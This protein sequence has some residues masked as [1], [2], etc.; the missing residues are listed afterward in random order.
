[1]LNE[2]EKCKEDFYYFLDNYIKPDNETRVY[3]DLIKNNTRIQINKENDKAKD[4]MYIFVLYVFLFGDCGNIGVLAKTILAASK[5]NLDIY[6][7]C[8]TLPDFLFDKKYHER[9]SKYLYTTKKEGYFNFASI[10]NCSDCV[11]FI[12]FTNLINIV[13]IKE[14]S[15]TEIE[16]TLEYCFLDAYSALN[17]KYYKNENVKIFILDNITEEISV[18]F[19]GEIYSINNFYKVGYNG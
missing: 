1:M 6:E 5:Y 19:G 11:P 10:P 14:L 18:T 2:T 7:L 9:I 16:E 15:K 3:I 13:D 8:K 17:N 4:A 12:G